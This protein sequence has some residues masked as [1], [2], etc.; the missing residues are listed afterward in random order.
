MTKKLISSII[1]IFAILGIM[2]ASNKVLAYS[3]DGYSIDMPSSFSSMGKN[4]W[5]KSSGASI[6]VQIQS[7]KGVAVNKKNLEDTVEQLKKQMSSIK[8]ESSEVTTF[9]GYKAM[10]IKYTYS[11]MAL[12]QYAIPTT[13][14]TYVVTVGAISAD[15]INSEDIQS[16]LK[17]FKI[18]N[19]KE[20]KS[21]I[22]VIGIIV[23][24]AVIG[25]VVAFVLSKKKAQNN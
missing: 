12:E 15:E 5:V 7:G 1:A 4:A 2:V 17:S 16:A 11:G 13:E 21:G 24:V 8:V 25:G 3:G 9:N 19:Y 10:H 14:K 22:G 6:N 20:P 23:V 18:D